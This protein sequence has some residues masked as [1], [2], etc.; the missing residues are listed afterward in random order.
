MRRIFAREHRIRLCA[1]RDENRTRVQQVFAVAGPLAVFAA[2]LFSEAHAVDGTVLVHIDGNG[3]EAL[4]EHRAFFKRFLDFFVVQRVGG[5]VDQAPPI[6]DRRAAPFLQHFENPGFA[7]F[8]LRFGALGA[9]R[10]RVMEK[11]FRD[12]ALFGVPA[13]AND[14]LAGLLHQGFVAP[15]EFLDLHDVVGERFGRRVDGGQ[16]AADH[17]RFSLMP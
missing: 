12:F 3:V 6:G 10:A 5:T 9:N 8:S 13:F 7:F 11:L 14:V 17:D 4:G 2:A 1:G 15:Q 16:T